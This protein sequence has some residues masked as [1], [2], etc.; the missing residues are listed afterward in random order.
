MVKKV[1][2]DEATSHFPVRQ[3]ASTYNPTDAKL[4]DCFAGDGYP[5]ITFASILKFNEMPLGKILSRL[6]EIGE[7]GMGCPVEIE[8]AV[9]LDNTEKP[10]FYILQI[11]PMVV[12]Q[13][14]INIKITDQDIQQAWC[15]R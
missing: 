13:S 12:A 2:I 15:V 7:K 11:R 4:R 5:V 1:E 8:F 10:H 6:L 9:N 14:R 3:L